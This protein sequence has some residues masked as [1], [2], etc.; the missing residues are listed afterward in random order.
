MGGTLVFIH[1][2]GVRQAAH[3]AGVEALKAGLARHGLA[4]VAVVG[5]SWGEQFGVD[6]DQVP[7]TLPPLPSTRAATETLTDAERLAAAWALLLD[8]PLFELRLIGQETSAAGTI[9][10]VGGLPPDQAASDRLVALAAALPNLDGTGLTPTE[11]AAAARGVGGSAELGAAA[12][13]TGT[14]DAPALTGAAARAVVATALAAH[15]ADPPGTAPLAA[16]D[17]AVRDDL[18]T[19]LEMALSG[20]PGRNLGDWIKGKVAG[21]AAAHATHW[22]QHRRDRV[23]GQ[24][25]PAIGDILHYQRRGDRI[26]AFVAAAL[27]GQAP[28]VVALGHSLGGIILVDL[29]SGPEA[30]PVDLLVTF[31]SQAPMLLALDALQVLRLGQATPRPF[32]PWLNIYNPDDLLSFVAQPIFAEIDGITDEPVFP[33]VPFPEAHGAYFQHDRFYQLLAGHWPE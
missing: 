14:A 13:V 27:R 11:L 8:D 24:S 16:I 10:V 25:V 7:L 21:F 12:I 1:G 20:G 4:D 22:I 6:L 29:L 3:D 15:R 32:T 19:R 28:P 26:S 17:V 23:A 2:T 30:P 33:G 5:C 9:V 31:G 18:V